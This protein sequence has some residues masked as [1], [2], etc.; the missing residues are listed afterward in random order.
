MTASDLT[1]PSE[2]EPT[3]HRDIAAAYLTEAD[4]YLNSGA[5]ELART[6]ALLAIGHALV[7]L[8]KDGIEVF[9]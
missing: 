5:V 7:D 9:H 6:H 2:P 4:D 3:K 1:H 8:T